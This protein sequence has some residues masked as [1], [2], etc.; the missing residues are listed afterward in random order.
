M[1]THSPRLMEAMFKGANLING[2]GESVLVYIR[3]ASLLLDLP[4]VYQT[5][6]LVRGVWSG[7]AVGALLGAAHDREKPKIDRIVK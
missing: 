7:A 5:L 2:A 4:E 6:F 1:Y 3:L